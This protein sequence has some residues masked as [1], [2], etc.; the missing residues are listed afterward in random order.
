MVEA[1]A[2]EEEGTATEAEAPHRLQYPTGAP[3][4]VAAGVGGLSRAA[5]GLA[6]PKGDA[7]QSAVASATAWPATAPAVVGVG[8]TRFF[9][10]P[11]PR[12]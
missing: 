4:G 10:L 8:V 12:A 7:E 3:P 2:E 1:A 11:L 6:A 9:A 5:R